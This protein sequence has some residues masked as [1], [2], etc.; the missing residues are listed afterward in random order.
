MASLSL[1]RFARFNQGGVRWDD[2]RCGVRYG[3]EID[4]VPVAL[5]PQF[6]CTL[7]LFLPPHEEEDEPDSPGEQN[8][9]SR[10]GPGDDRGFGFLP[11]LFVIK[12]PASAHGWWGVG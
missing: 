6:F 11:G 4:D 1:V 10:D 3:D 8:A 7:F 5:E 9:S 2:E 12:L